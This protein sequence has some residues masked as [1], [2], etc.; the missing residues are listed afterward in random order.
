[1]QRCRQ[2]LESELRALAE[3]IS[4][5]GTWLNRLVTRSP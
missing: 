5:L 2:A 4:T 3:E 1:M